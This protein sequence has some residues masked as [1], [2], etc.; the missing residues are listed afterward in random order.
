MSKQTSR[1]GQKNILLDQLL[2]FT[3]GREK[4]SNV[5]INQPC[6]QMKLASE[7]Q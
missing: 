6:K 1:G 3:P 2:N 5:Q 4:Y 7:A